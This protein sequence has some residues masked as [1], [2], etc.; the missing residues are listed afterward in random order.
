MDLQVLLP[1]VELPVEL[2]VELLQLCLY[3]VIFQE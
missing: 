3:Q 2:P 1:L